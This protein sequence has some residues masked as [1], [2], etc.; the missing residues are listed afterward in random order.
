MLA[1]EVVQLSHFGI[2]IAFTIENGRG[3]T[4]ECVVLAC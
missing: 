1:L 4:F 2:S 3:L